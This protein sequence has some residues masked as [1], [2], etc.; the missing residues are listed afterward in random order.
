MEKHKHYKLYK[1]GKKWCTMAI[2]TL[3]A[4]LGLAGV[5]NA[6]TD[7]SGVSVDASINTEKANVTSTDQTVQN[8]SESDNSQSLDTQKVV[9]DNVQNLEAS[10]ASD[11]QESLPVAPKS[12]TKNGWVK[13]D[14]GWTYYQNGETSS[15]RTYS[16]LPTITS[17]GVGDGHNWYLTENGVVLSGVQQWANTYYDF[18][19]NTYLRVDNDYR[20]SQWGDWYMFGNDGRIATQVY[21]WAGTYY[22]FDPLTYLRV[23]NDYRQSQWGDWYM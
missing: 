2:V 1:S 21:Q 17:N 15:G 23:D 11:E 16:Y 13:E 8:N 4:T 10:P 6:D 7:N 18:D 14:Q 19:A 12:V 3:A 9:N 20:Q 5:V 22:Y